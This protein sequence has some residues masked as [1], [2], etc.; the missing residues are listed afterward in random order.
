M[1]LLHTTSFLLCK[2]FEPGIGGDRRKWRGG[3]GG[4][5]D[6]AG[7]TAFLVSAAWPEASLANHPRGRR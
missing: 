3:T 6:A 2:F 1:K 4:A 5:R 7:T